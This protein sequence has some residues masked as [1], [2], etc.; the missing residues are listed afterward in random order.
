MIYY[1]YHKG[2]NSSCYFFAVGF[3]ISAHEQYGSVVV[4]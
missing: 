2:A 1:P 4:L 3:C